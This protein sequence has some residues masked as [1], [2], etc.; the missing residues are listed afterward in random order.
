VVG[1]Q[2]IRLIQD[3][4]MKTSLDDRESAPE[5]VVDARQNEIVGDAG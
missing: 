3:R 1:D 2:P 4:R 5:L